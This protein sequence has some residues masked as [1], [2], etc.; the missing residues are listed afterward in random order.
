MTAN[1]FELHLS[2]PMVSTYVILASTNMLDWIP[3][4]TN[5][6]LTGSAVFTDTDAIKKPARFYR[7]TAR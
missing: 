1:G 6:T 7:A 2:G 5:S 4:S 3:I